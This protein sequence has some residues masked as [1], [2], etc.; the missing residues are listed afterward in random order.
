[1]QVPPHH[2]FSD[3]PL[4]RQIVEAEVDSR[5]E[6]A[7]ADAR[8]AYVLDVMDRIDADVEACV[9]R[10]ILTPDYLNDLIRR[11]TIEALGETAA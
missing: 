3:D 5:A 11:R 2:S 7:T 1:M 8:R 4:F 9:Q 6:N 10:S